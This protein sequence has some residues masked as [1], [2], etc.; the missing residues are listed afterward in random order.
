MQDQVVDAT[1]AAE[2]MP[3]RRRS[4]FSFSLSSL[5]LLMLLVS[6]YLAGRYAANP[7]P[8]FSKA[9]SGKWQAEMPSGAVQPT[10]LTHL[11]DD[12]FLFSS[13][14]NVFN[15]HYQW[16]D[17]Q[18]VIVKPSDKRMVGLTW[19]WDGE[20]LQLINEPAGTPTGS[21]YLGTVL[22]RPKDK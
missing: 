1:H 10:T 21:S 20:Q 9:L 17:D 11:E 2:V 19:K 14:A 8:L 13:R 6:V 22:V 18:L 15:G 4:W 12:I 3:R 5:L 16:K 7:R